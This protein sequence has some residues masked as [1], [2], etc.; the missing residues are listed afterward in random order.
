ML[1]RE[2]NIRKKSKTWTLEQ[3][4]DVFKEFKELYGKYPSTLDFDKSD[5]LPTS[6]SIQRNFG[7]V[8]KLRQALKID[9]MQDYTKDEYRSNIAKKTLEQSKKYEDNFYYL[10]S[11]IPEIRVHEHKILRP[12]RICCDFYIYTSEK[13]GI[14]VDLFYAQDAY[15]LSRIIVYKAKRYSSLSLQV[16][17][18]LVKNTDINQE[19]INVIVSNKKNLLPKNIQVLTE[20]SFKGIIRVGL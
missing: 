17:F 20:D 18:V 3:I 10:I 5:F 8:I 19:K 2:S 11:M 15:S 12:G 13:Q 4:R 6:R 1:Y 7:G 16:Y 9:G 14:A